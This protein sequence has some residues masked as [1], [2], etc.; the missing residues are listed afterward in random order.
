MAE[1][2]TEREQEILVCLVEG[3]SN[4]EIA[5]R[6]HLAYGSVKWY[7]SQIYGKLAVSNREEAITQ[8]TRLGLIRTARAIE[9]PAWH[10]LPRQSTAF[11]GRQQEL[12]EITGLL[13]E[14]DTRLLSIL[15]PGGMGKTR[16]ALAVAAALIPHYE[17]GVYFVPLASLSSSDDMVTAIAAHI[18]FNLSGGETPRQQLLDYLRNTETLLILD[19]FEHLLDGVDLVSEMLNNAPQLTLLVTSREKLKLSNE[20]VFSL[21]GLPYTDWQSTNDALEDDAVQLFLQTAHRIR[22]DFELHGDDLPFLARICRLTNG[23]PLA[24]ILAAGW[25]DMLTLEQIA[26][27]MQQ[28]IDILETDLRDVP[29]RH[30]S[31]RATFNKSWQRLSDDERDGFMKLSIFRGFTAD[32]AEAVA[33]ASKR[34]LRKLIDKALIQTLHAGRYDIHELLRQFAEEKLFEAGQFATTRNAQGTYYMDLLASLEADSKISMLVKTNTI[35]TEFENI[36]QAW[37]WAVDHRQYESLGKAADCLRKTQAPLHLTRA[38]YD[39]FQAT[40][41]LPGFD[42]NSTYH[43]VRDKIIL[44]MEQVNFNITNKKI[45][46]QLVEDILMRAQQHADQH[47]IA[48]CWSLLSAYYLQIG[49]VETGLD[50][51]QQAL[52]L[53]RI[54]DDPQLLSNLMV[55]LAYTH[56]K[57]GRSDEA[58]MMLEEALD[59]RRRANNR[60]GELYSLHHLGNLHLLHG[61]LLQAG[62]YFD[63][64]L[65][66]ESTHWINFDRAYLLFSPTILLLLRGQL[67]DAE[68]HI[69]VMH[70]AGQELYR[71]YR[72]IGLELEGVLASIRGDNA[73]LHALSDPSRAH[74]LNLEALSASP[75][76]AWCAAL[77]HC[78][79][80]DDRR[81][82]QSLRDL[83]IYS[84]EMKSYTLKH[85]GLPVA[86]VLAAQ[87]R[88]S[89]RAVELLGLAHT[90][91]EEMTGWLDH[92]QIL[93]EVEVDLKAQLT[94][95]DYNRIW[96]A[97]AQLNL[98]QVSRELIKEYSNTEEDLVTQVNQSLTNPLTAKELEVLSLLAEELTNPQIAERLFITTGTVKGHVNKILHKLDVTSRHQA[99]IEAQSLQLL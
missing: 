15:A 86:A 77:I 20:T 75:F 54:L 56:L 76:G 27:E 71:Q 99:V 43:P 4:H 69:A 63:K 7:N 51:G 5:S 67:A 55:R 42:A 30:R 26:D 49:N 16:L 89:E 81:S 39:L 40:L 57:F 52:H 22:P 3:L 98:E 28:S 80:G 87:E 85:V 46:K 95:D 82:K 68:V 48:W 36:R 50:Y 84:V 64:M 14:T 78:E 53:W 58:Q 90:A 88:N 93:K 72:G 73:T 33:G 47:H 24:L 70:Q 74:H 19:N 79:L 38:Y 83:L 65:T 97:G 44:I 66:I 23:I 8:A 17:D 60:K 62:T 45:D 31:M 21:D 91:P 13:L 37:W 9:N 32:A 41:L 2:L 1:A 35:E 92:W 12:S 29:E 25:L 59:V 34:H 6:L 61:R 10:N 96:Q 94:P 11:V 18:D